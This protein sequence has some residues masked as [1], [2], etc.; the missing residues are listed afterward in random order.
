[1]T[2]VLVTPITDRSVRMGSPRSAMAPH[3]PQRGA[4]TRLGIGRGNHGRG[5]GPATPRSLGRLPR[6]TPRPSRLTTHRIGE[7]LTMPADD[8]DNLITEITVDAYGEDEQST[9]FLQAFT[10]E[11]DTPVTALVLG[12]EIEV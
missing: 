1:M 4:G 8:I 12:T 5:Q 6:R 10:D 3:R 11:V 9:A 7:A 2:A